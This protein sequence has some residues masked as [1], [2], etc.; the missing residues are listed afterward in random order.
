MSHLLQYLNR[1]SSFAGLCN[2]IND[3]NCFKTPIKY[4]FTII[5]NTRET[6]NTNTIGWYSLLI[7]TELVNTLIHLEEN[8]ETKFKP[9]SQYNVLTKFFTQ[10]IAIT[11]WCH[12]YYIASDTSKKKRRRL[13][14]FEYFN[15]TYLLKKEVTHGTIFVLRLSESI[16]NLMNIIALHPCEKLLRIIQSLFSYGHCNIY[17]SCR[18]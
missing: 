6:K 2:H 8:L 17:H 13:I 7:T 14:C 3:L 1:F 15:N 10:H 5:I 9:S 4:P 11:I 18:T 12:P 16:W